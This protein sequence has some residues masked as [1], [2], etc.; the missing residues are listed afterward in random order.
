MTCVRELIPGDPVN[1]YV[2]R[3][4]LNRVCSLWPELAEDCRR[5]CTPDQG[6]N[7]ITYKAVTLEVDTNRFR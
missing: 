6:A 7:T 1:I 5:C 3:I 2:L 4:L